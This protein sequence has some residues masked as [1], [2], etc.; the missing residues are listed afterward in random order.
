MGA[1]LAP[2][3]GGG[4]GRGQEEVGGAGGQEAEQEALLPWTL[5]RR[6]VTALP[7]VHVDGDSAANAHFLFFSWTLPMSAELRLF[8]AGQEAELASRRRGWKCPP[9]TAWPTS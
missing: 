3:W 9:L 4:G 6:V 8:G 2:V 5:A 7:S 1:E